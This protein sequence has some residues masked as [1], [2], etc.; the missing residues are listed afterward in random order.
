MKNYKYTYIYI[1]IYINY[2]IGSKLQVTPSV[3][4][5]KLYLF[6]TIDFYKI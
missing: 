6:K 5:K 1:Y 3:T 4:P 2:E